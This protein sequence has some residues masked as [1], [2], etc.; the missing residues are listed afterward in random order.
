MVALLF[1]LAI[2]LCFTVFLV[3][4]REKHRRVDDSGNPAG[5]TDPWKDR[6]SKFSVIPYRDFSVIF[7]G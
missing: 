6:S 5:S 2:I 4:L 1:A 7:S 3:G